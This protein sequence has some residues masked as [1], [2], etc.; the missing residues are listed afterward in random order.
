MFLTICG[1]IEKFEII[2]YKIQYKNS[3][4]FE[5]VKIKLI[6]RNLDLI[7]NFSN[8][9]GKKNINIKIVCEKGFL[10]FN[11]YL[12]NDNY[13]FYKKKEHIKS[14]TTSIENILNLFLNNIHKKNKISNIN[15]GIKE[16]YLSTAILKKISSIRM[17]NNNEFKN[18]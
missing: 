2:D 7:F 8:F 10:K 18:N 4:I 15:I 11:S 16:H 5:K 17:K 14:R 6:K 1:D 3:F 13:I 9:Q 12:E